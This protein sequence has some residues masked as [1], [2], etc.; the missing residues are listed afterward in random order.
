MVVFKI[1]LDL[2][3]SEILQKMVEF[4][5]YKSR[6]YIEMKEVKYKTKWNLP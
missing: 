3:V 6:L 2:S 1:D 4:A 5:S